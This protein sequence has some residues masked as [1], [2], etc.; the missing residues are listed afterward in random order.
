MGAIAGTGDFRRLVRN[1]RKAKGKVL[2]DAS[3]PALLVEY[4]QLHQ[5]NKA[6]T[7]ELSK[8]LAVQRDRPETPCHFYGQ[9]VGDD[10][11]TASYCDARH[12][13]RLCPWCTENLLPVSERLTAIRRRLGAV[14]RLILRAGQQLAIESGRG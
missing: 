10:G 4:A 6:E 5:R 1:L 3:I 12:D 13:R 9:E 11:G 2:V 8:V 14:R 7:W